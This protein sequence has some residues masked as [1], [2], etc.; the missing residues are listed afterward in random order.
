VIA[1]IRGTLERVDTDVIVVDVGGVGFSLRIT[2]SVRGQLPKVG[3]I[4][5]LHS[6]MIVRDNDI[7]LY[8][9]SS[10]EELELFNVLLG[11]SG[12]GPRTALATLS[13]FSPEALRSVISS[14][15]AAALARTPGIGRKTA[16]RLLVDLRDK[17]GTYVPGH[18]GAVSPV[19]NEVAAALTSLGYSLSEARAAVSAIPDDVTELD[20]RI[21]E[22]LRFLGGR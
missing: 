21:L 4:V 9:F 19:D 1:S 20:A 6:R 2:E 17:I 13:A 8:G 18:G 22:A 5:E 14:G 7:S 11:V 12:V 15:D 16:E 10:V 3:Q